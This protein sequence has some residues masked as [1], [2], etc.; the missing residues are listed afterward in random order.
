[1]T[2][3]ADSGSTKVDW[4][5]VSDFATQKAV[6]T[7]GINPV[8]IPK[9]EIVRTLRESI[10]DAGG[11]DADKV[12]F[13]GAGVLGESYNTLMDCLHEV[14]P[15]A[16]CHA[17]SDIVAAARALFGDQPGI[18]AI[19]GTGS[20]SC[21]YDGK[22][23]LKSVH[24]GGFI[25][26]DEGSGADMGKRLVSD[27]I[28]GLVPK[29]IEKEFRTRYQLD[30]PTIVQKVYREPMPSRFLASFSTFIEEFRHHPYMDRLICDSFTSFLERNITAYDYRRSEVS[31]IGSIAFVYQEELAK[32]VKDCGM[33]M[34]QVMRS[35]IEGLVKYHTE[36]K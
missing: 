34:G 25:I 27:Y 28:K 13:Y 32:C 9:D 4:R 30:Y 26:G 2:I 22:I 31:F 3:I 5:I 6:Q 18:A 16:E 29:T 19:L 14:F 33:R 1:M 21:Y 36:S 7:P 10:A 11:A 20:N 35:P 15:K 12:F 23:V 8:Y 24:A 17:E